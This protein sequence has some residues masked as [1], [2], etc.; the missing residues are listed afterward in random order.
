MAVRSHRNPAVG[1]LKPILLAECVNRTV[2]NRNMDKVTVVIPVFNEEFSIGPL[3]RKLSKTATETNQFFWRFIFVDDGSVDGSRARLGELERLEQAVKV[4]FLK[5]NFGVTQAL[6]AGFD[7]AEGDYIVTF[8]CN[9][10][11]E[12]KDIPKILAEL[13][14]GADVCVG[15]RIA[16]HKRKSA[17]QAFPKLMNRT[18]SALS[19]LRLSDYECRLRGYKKPLVMGLHLP[20]DLHRYLPAYF[21]WQGRKISQISVHG[22][23]QSAGWK[24]K[25]RSVKRSAKAMLDLVL[26]RFF[27][28]YSVRPFYVFGGLS[29]LCTLGGASSILTAIFWKTADGISLIE[30]PLPLLSALCFLSAILLLGLGIIAEFLLRIYRAQIGLE[31]YETD[32]PIDSHRGD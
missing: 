9:L 10:E 12:P 26:L 16:S 18:I 13:A 20:G 28:R 7:A 17:D 19:G 3:W 6:Q 25:R 23:P 11:Y 32:L 22:V 15:S 5:R 29:L 1:V 8:P 21:F 24:N 14:G 2:G 27:Y 31:F 4:I 30:T